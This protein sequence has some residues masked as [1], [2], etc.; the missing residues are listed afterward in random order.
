MHS[1]KHTSLQTKIAL[2]FALSLLGF[3]GTFSVVTYFH[4]KNEFSKNAAS[5][6]HQ[7]FKEYNS[8]EA[9][10]VE[11]LAGHLIHISVLYSIPVFFLALFLG[12]LL[13]QKSMQPVIKLNSRLEGIKA[14]KLHTK[15]EIPEAD[16]EIQAIVTAINQLLERIDVAYKNLSDFSSSVAHELRTPLTLMRLQLEEHAEK[17][18]PTLAEALQDELNQMHKLVEQCLLLARSEQGQIELHYENTSLQ[19]ITESLL[20]PFVLLCKEA[21]RPLDFTYSQPNEVMVVSWIVRQ[22]L[23]NLLENAHKHGRGKISL[24]IKPI[25]TGVRLSLENAIDQKHSSGTRLGLRIV[26]ALVKAHGNINYT[27]TVNEKNIY[28]VKLDFISRA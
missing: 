10:R 16:S 4:L 14:S 19:V 21:S 25:A 20:E 27:T 28:R 18:D 17:I 2:W 13:A 3:V 1:V 23:Q 11:E 15:I 5:T 12:K 8:F 7:G 9:H 26:N 22:V 24:E 6:H